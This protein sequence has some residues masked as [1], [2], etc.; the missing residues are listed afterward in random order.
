MG[1]VVFVQAADVILDA[2]SW[3]SVT[4]PFT[5]PEAYRP[6]RRKLASC[7]V[8]NSSAMSTVLW[9]ET[10]GTITVRNLGGAG[11]HGGRYGMPSYPIG[12]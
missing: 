9:V 1:G 6:R 10:D 7:T 11:V 2:D 5:V 8:N 4:C 3:A 12:L